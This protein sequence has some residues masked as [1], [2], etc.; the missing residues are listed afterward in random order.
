MTGPQGGVRP[1]VGAPWLERWAA[2]LLAWRVAALVLCVV[3]V[4]GLAL[5][6][7]RLHVGHSVAGFQRSDLPELRAA[8]AHY[9][10]FGAPEATLL[11]GLPAAEPF[12]AATMQRL[13]AF[14]RAVRGIDGVHRTFTAASVA[15]FARLEGEA[16]RAAAARSRTWR[17]LLFSAGGD[18]LGAVVQLELGRN[19][20]RHL[21]AVCDA[22][23][24][25]AAA[26]GF[27][28]A[29]LSG[30]PFHRA[31]LVAMIRADQALFLP[32]GGA[33]STLLLL[34][35]VPGVLYALLAMLVVPCT[36][37]ATFGVMAW[38]GVP[39]TMLTSTLPCL[40]MAM[41][42]ADGVHL[43]LRFQD[44]RRAGHA[45]RAA[46]QRTLV[47]LALPCLLTSATTIIGF[48]TLALTVV[49][50]L[51]HM[52]VFAAL[53]MTFAYAFTM[54]LVPPALSF[55]RQVPPVRR[56]NVAAALAAACAR[57]V[58]RW[59]RRLLAVQAGV[60][61]VAAVIGAGVRRDERL[62][63]DLWPSS[64]VAAS[65]R[66][67][68]ER[69]V[70]FLPG[71]VLVT[72]P[73]G[74]AYS[75]EQAALARLVTWLEV[76]P[77]VDRSLSLLDLQ[78]DG[79]PL[80][81]LSL[82]SQWLD[83]P[84]R[85]LSRDGKTAR[86]LLFERDVGSRARRAFAAALAAYA[87][88][89]APL[90]VQL[91]GAG[92][93]ATRL[94]DELMHDMIASFQGSLLAIWL[95]IGLALRSVRDGF[96]AVLP[97]LLAFAVTLAVMALC[98]IPLRPV[99]VISFCIGFGLAVDNT[100]HMLARYRAARATGLTPDAA[101]ADAVLVAGQPVIV[102]TL[103]LLVGFSTILW[104]LFRG[105]FDFGVL[106]LTM[107]SSALLAAL[108]GLPSLLRWRNNA[109]GMIDARQTPP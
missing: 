51:R 93:V 65:H 79:V 25:A 4:A 27:A 97:N 76:Q 60:L 74:F 48:A 13:S 104:S 109:P 23:A 37:I 10:E 58:Q 86:V 50:D 21:R 66:A 101:I 28:G 69:F 83:L 87:P 42:V 53:G 105:T 100:T 40:L 30:L 19:D 24:A 63:D 57:A 41:S 67:Y 11:V 94:V 108:L 34:W 96:L 106:V 102:T 82:A 45:P 78:S 2:R 47:A 71:E 73:T 26:H 32:L 88:S 75:D 59:P 22:V 61:V 68:A 46:A 90:Q 95:V 35:L 84:A 43:V 107:L 29:A 3:L 8:T 98:G 85:L 15:P 77:H 103:L 36:L 52:G 89:V 31:E 81:M 72:S 49:D 16:L 44:E 18:A 7:R 6:L 38:C 64:H 39:V 55:T 80:L 14:E 12:A 54:L 5:P 91:A 92:V 9:A 62:G 99:A 20:P 56:V 33:V 70:S 17:R 1:A